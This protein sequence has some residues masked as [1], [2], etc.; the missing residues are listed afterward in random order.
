MRSPAPACGF[1]LVLLSVATLFGLLV[2]S[3]MAP[4]MSGGTPAAIEADAATRTAIS[5][6][7]YAGTEAGSF[8]PVATGPTGRTEMLFPDGSA[9]TVAPE[10]KGILDRFAYDPETR[11]GELAFRAIE[12]HF[13]FVGGRLG[14]NG[15]VQLTTPTALIHIQGGIVALDVNF[16]GETRA[17]FLAGDRLQVTAEGITR[18]A[19]RPGSVILIKPGKGPENPQPEAGTGLW[20]VIAAIRVPF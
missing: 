18:V 19:T 13:R 16:D 7:V 1:G 9:L 6:V 12:G 14:R 8:D 11:T 20:Q 17:E 15:Q 3:F 4:A 5:H 10:S 2:L